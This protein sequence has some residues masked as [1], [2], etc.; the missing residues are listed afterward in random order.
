MDGVNVRYFPST[1]MRRL[2]WS[3][4]MARALQAELSGFDVVHLHS[5][6]LWPTWAAARSARRRAV[7]YVLS[8][9]GMMVKDL[10]QRKSRWLKRAWIGLIE[11]QNLERAAAIHVTSRTEAAELS[12]F[13]IKL[14]PVITIPNGISL[15]EHVVGAASEDVDA[16]AR[17]PALILFLGRI[18]WKKGLDRLIPAMTAVPEAHLAIVGNDEEGLLPALESSIDRHGV[19]GRVT[20]LNR[21]VGRTDRDRLMA[22]AKVFALPSYSENF[23]NTVLEALAVGCP[24]VVTPDVGAAEVVRDSGG[25]LVVGGDPE[26]FGRALR[27]LLDNPA[28]AEMGARGRRFVTERFA[29]ASVAREMEQA[30]LH[31]VAARRGEMSLAR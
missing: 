15:P 1:R 11:R 24:V 30:Y 19:R 10:I 4:P 23:G 16:L 28:R 3:P 31:L 8:P 22:S 13:R 12:R 27:E 29:W 14:P 5:V 9:R 26:I 2:Y 17:H 18:N 6:F 20:V 25:G 21:V 7:P